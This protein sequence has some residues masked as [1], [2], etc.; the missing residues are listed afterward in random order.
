MRFDWIRNDETLE[1]QDFD[2][3]IFDCDMIYMF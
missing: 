3:H 1:K 2:S